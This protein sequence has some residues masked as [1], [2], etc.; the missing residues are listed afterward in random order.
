MTITSTLYLVRGNHWSVPGSPSLATFDK[1]DAN[2]FAASLVQ[3]MQN[4]VDEDDFQSVGAVTGDNW[5]ER[6]L[7]VQARRIAAES[8]DDLAIALRAV[9]AMSSV[10]AADVCKCDVSIEQMTVVLPARPS[11][12]VY[13]GMVDGKGGIELITASTEDGIKQAAIERAG[14]TYA[15][16]LKYAATYEERTKKSWD[17]GDPIVDFM[18]SDLDGATCDDCFSWQYDWIDE[19]LPGGD[20]AELAANLVEAVSH[21]IFTDAEECEGAVQDVVDAAEFVSAELERV[22]PVEA[23]VIPDVAVILEGGLVQ[24]AMV[25]GGAANVY[26]VDYDTEGADEDDLTQVPQ[27]N[28][29]F[30][31]AFV[32]S[33]FAD[34]AWGDQWWNVVTEQKD[35]TAP[36]P[37]PTYLHD[38]EAC[39]S[40]HNN[41]GNDICTDCGK[42]L[43][44][45]GYE[46]PVTQRRIY[47]SVIIRKGWE[48]RV[49]TAFTE[50][51]RRADLLEYYREM[52]EDT[53]PSLPDDVDLAEI[54]NAIAAYLS[55][56]V[57]ID[58][59]YITETAA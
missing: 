22:Q 4:D 5:K 12:R 3:T 1:D 36:E 47:T 26:V 21:D 45:A 52:R 38:P 25:R 24:N 30:Q 8:G 33:A 53:N 37:A 13:F 59:G 32:S 2:A 27:N 43:N 20:L 9:K 40:N 44:P 18:Q 19:P 48:P 10:E 50:E 57:S 28:G 16:Y 6:L 46:H 7:T 17:S 23:P 35:D 15:E 58:D 39:P 11:R 29:G 42:D 31:D 54:T 55:E 51:E 41:E 56:T 14:G 49:A 34:E